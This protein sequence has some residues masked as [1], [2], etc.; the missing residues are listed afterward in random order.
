MNRG[1][2]GVLILG[3]I[4]MFGPV[5]LGGGIGPVE[6]GLWALLF[7]GWVV[8]LVITLRKHARS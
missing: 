5:A 8:L 1:L 7:G 3:L 4:V 6:L 2:V